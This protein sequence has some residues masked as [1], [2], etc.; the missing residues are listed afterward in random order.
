MR[1][2]DESGD[3]WSEVMADERLKGAEYIAAGGGGRRWWW[4]VLVK[5]KMMDE[6]LKRKK[7]KKNEIEFSNHRTKIVVYSFQNK[8]MI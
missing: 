4:W 5:M 3:E 1:R 2:Y 8:K 7:Q 6:F